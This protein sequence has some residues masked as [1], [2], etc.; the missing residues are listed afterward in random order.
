MNKPSIR[1]EHGS[2][3]SFDNDMARWNHH[4]EVGGKIG[5]IAVK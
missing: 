1:I 3:E 4:L 2:L 5:L